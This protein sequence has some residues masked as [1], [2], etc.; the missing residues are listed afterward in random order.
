MLMRTRLSILV[1]VLTIS[2]ALAGCAQTTTVTSPAAS[3]PTPGAS[4]EP[5]PSVQIAWFWSDKS[6]KHPVFRFVALIHN[7]GPR[8]FEGLQTEWIAYDADEAI[9]AAHLRLYRSLLEAGVS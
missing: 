9:A 6:T 1:V 3:A 7:P 5:S 8:A 2:A 4:V